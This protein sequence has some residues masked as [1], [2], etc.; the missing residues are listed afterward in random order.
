ML[1]SDHA[2]PLCPARRRRIDSDPLRHRLQFRQ[3]HRSGDDRERA[4]VRAAGFEPKPGR[5]L[6][7]PAP[8]GRLAGVLFGL[9]TAD[10]P[11]RDLFRPG[12]LSTLL[13]PGTYRFA[14]APYDARLAALAFALNAYQF[15]RY[16]KGEPR[17]AR[18]MLPEGLDGE[19]LTL[20]VE[21]VTLCRD[22]INTPANDMGP[23]ELEE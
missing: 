3:G 23:A 14:N 2:P 17:K 8:D 16:R 4:F 10:E 15:T 12:A 1:R 11:V 13:P 21:G 19:E 20:I 6:V 5:H 9:E 7:V 22:L 18:L